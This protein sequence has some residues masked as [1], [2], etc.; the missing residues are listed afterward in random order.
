MKGLFRTFKI[1]K[2]KE[3]YFYYKKSIEEKKIKKNVIN[4]Y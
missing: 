1:T 3:K 4:Y 2:Y